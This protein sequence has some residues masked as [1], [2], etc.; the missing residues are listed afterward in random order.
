MLD[1]TTGERW[2]QMTD[3]ER[4]A[5]ARNTN[6]LVWAGRKATASVASVLGFRAEV[7]V[8]EPDELGTHEA[9][10]AQF[11]RPLR[12]LREYVVMPADGGGAS[13]FDGCEPF[14]T[15]AD[16]AGRIVLMQRG[17]CPLTQKALNAQNAGAVAALIAN[18]VPGGAI[19]LGGV[20]PRVV[21]PSVGISQELG[22][23][24]AAAA[25]PF[26]NIFE[27]PRIR[28]GTTAGFPRLYAP[29][30][31]APGSSVSHWDTSLTPNVLMEPFINSDLTST[32]K[33][34]D[35]LTKSLLND[36]GW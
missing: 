14:P 17:S 29:A 5:S 34:P 4:A 1:V 22:A 33:N 2:I 23:A 31:F 20:D 12:P 36:I 10:R 25:D 19:Y 6:N 26:V 18:N 27:N 8:L 28:M 7:R 30:T 11:G 15:A 35:D 9:Q 24:L 13:P 3:A 16:A 32:V 21:I